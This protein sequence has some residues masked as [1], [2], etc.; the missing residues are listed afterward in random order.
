MKTEFRIPLPSANV[1]P[2]MKK[3]S[4]SLSEYFIRF[5]TAGALCERSPSSGLEVEMQSELNNAIEACY[6]TGT[7]RGGSDRAKASHDLKKAAKELGATYKTSDLVLPDGQVPDIGSMTGPAAVAFTLKPGD[8]SGPIS[9]GDNG[10]VLTVR[11]RQAP[12]DQDFLA[13]KDQIRETLMQKKQNEVF[14]LYLETL[15]QSLEK[16]GK[17]KINQAELQTLT[18]SRTEE[19]E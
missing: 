4:K 11:E 17:I 18:K 5:Q 19:N 3:K 2:E 13:K 9:S 1:C 15:R 14:G 7:S 16:S 8:I 10:A 6:S 12:T